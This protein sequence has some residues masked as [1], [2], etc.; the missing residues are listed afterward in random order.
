MASLEYLKK[1]IMSKN[2]LLILAAVLAVV[3]LANWFL[4]K[5]Q[6]NKID[7]DSNLSQEE[8][9]NL[10]VNFFGKTL[11]I[12]LLFGVVA[13]FLIVWFISEKS[14]SVKNKN[15]SSEL[16]EVSSSELKEDSQTLNIDDVI[17][18]P[19]TE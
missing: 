4:V 14:I 3:L 11:L 2:G 8:K 1:T 19:S 15:P 16:K 13:Y 5:Y 7:V 18:N 9:N 10:H 17:V 6:N 12:L